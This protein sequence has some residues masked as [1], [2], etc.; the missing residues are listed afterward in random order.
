VALFLGDGQ[1]GFAQ[2]ASVPGYAIYTSLA[3]A[4]INGNGTPD[5]IFLNGNY[6]DVALGHGDGTFRAVHEARL[7][8]TRSSSHTLSVGDVNDD[9]RIDIFAAQGETSVLLL[10]MP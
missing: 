1:G 7:P 6:V 8:R 2:S 10:N 5:L 9:G 3:A 4:D